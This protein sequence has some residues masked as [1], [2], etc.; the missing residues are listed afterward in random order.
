[1]FLT[2]MPVKLGDTIPGMV[3][4][5]LLMPIRMDAYCG[6]RSKWF[7]ANPL[8]ANAPRPTAMVMQIMLVTGC[9]SKA[10]NIMKTVCA[11]KAPQLKYRLTCVVVR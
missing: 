5:V 10:A 7:T 4:N 6:A 1:M 3:A 2:R 8:Q 9:S 11:R